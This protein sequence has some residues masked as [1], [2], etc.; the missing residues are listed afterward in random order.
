MKVSLII[1]VYNVEAFLERCLDSVQNQTYKDTEVIIVNDGSTDSCP[2]IIE[3]YVE[4]NPNF[5][6]FTIENSGQGGARNYGIEKATG[7]YVAFLDSDD[8]IAP[9]CIE[10]LVET[11]QKHNSDIVVCSC[12]DVKEDGTVISNVG[13]N[14]SNKTTSISE[15]PEI[16]FNRVAPWGKLFRKSVF[17]DLRFATR[18]WY[19]DMRLIPKLYLNAQKIS[20]IED[21]LFYYVQRAGSTMNNSNAVRNLEILETFDDLISYFKS[22]NVYETFKAELEFLIIDHIAVAAVTRVALCNA[23]E[24]KSVLEKMEEYISKFDDLYQNKYIPTL[25]SNKKLILKLNKNK[26]YFLTALCMKLKKMVK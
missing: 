14:I 18:V 10:R 17:G 25:S 4:K 26:L 3:K 9:N 7:E 12:Y 15:N 6:G 20:Y 21:P 23:T 24:K 19:E 11:A 8:Y 1:P 2:A 16:L 22:K 13:N 5:K